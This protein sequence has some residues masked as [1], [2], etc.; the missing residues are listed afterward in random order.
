MSQRTADS[1]KQP[2]QTTE[3]SLEKEFELTASRDLFSDYLK[4]IGRYPLLTREEEIDLGTKIQ[5]MMQ[6]EEVRRKLG[7][8]LD[9]FIKVRKLDPVATKRLYKVG[10]RAKEKLV[11]HNLRLVVSVA[12]R[13]NTINLSIY[14]M[15]QEGNIGLIR[16]A[17][18]YNPVKYDVKFSTY[19]S[20]WIKESVNKGITNGGRSIRLPVHITDKIRV[21]RR[22]KRNFYMKMNR[23]PTVTEL[24]ELTGFSREILAR[25]SP[26]V[27]RPVSIDAKID[28]DLTLIDYIADPKEDGSMPQLTQ[29]HIERTTAELLS[30]IEEEEYSVLVGIYGLFGKPRMDRVEYAQVYGI[31]TAKVGEIER[32]A[33]KKL[34]AEFGA[35]PEVK[36]VI[37]SCLS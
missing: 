16:G 32:R 21:L 6:Y 10:E 30:Y 12:R 14:D 7:I 9:D 5:E 34:R 18:K 33:L 25:I 15:V 35:L 19:A 26:Y 3:L 17:E 8:S 27:S 13:Y 29:E 1:P 28:T 31:S 11:T 20:W 36:A 22:E 23:Y 24:I 2:K 37:L 4:E